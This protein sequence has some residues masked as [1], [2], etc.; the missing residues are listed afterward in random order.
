MKFFDLFSGIGGFHLGM[1]RAGHECVGACEIDKYKNIVYKK[2]FPNTK[3]WGDVKTVNPDELPDFEVLCAGFPCQAFSIAG[4]RRGFED[5]R[6]TIFFE[7]ARIAKEKRP[8]LLLLENVKGLLSHKQGETYRTIRDTLDEMGYTVEWQLLNSKYF[9]PQNR[10]RIIIIGH[11]RGERF[12]EIFPVGET[13]E[14]VAG[15]E[16]KEGKQFSHIANCIDANYYKGTDKHGQRTMIVEPTLKRLN[17]PKHSFHRIYH[18]FG[19]ARTLECGGGKSGFY[20]VPVLTPN[21]A[22]KRQNG[23]RFKTNG[24]PMFTLT[25]QDIHGIFDG[26][27]VRRLTPL[28]CERLQCFPD[29]WTEGVSDTQRYRGTGDAVTVDVVNYIGEMLQ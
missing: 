22:K 26:Y 1:E 13:N 2:R 4:K 18:S 21:R 14:V 28:E 9:V 29:G 12:R 10:E 11:L 6:G 24:E 3:I 16:Q 27:R 19:I 15:D 20:A 7:I 25:T 23:R 5:T 17:N 8:R